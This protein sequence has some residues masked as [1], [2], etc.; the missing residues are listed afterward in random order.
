WE[1]TSQGHFEVIHSRFS[2]FFFHFILLRQFSRR[3]IVDIKLWICVFFFHFIL[4]RQFSTKNP[5]PLGLGSNSLVIPNSNDTHYAHRRLTSN[6]SRAFPN[7]DSDCRSIR[8]ILGFFG[9]PPL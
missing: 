3:N 2:V 6:A 9:S 5:T 1:L 8:N 7:R 4:L